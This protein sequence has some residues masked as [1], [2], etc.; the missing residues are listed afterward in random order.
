MFG[1]G[2]IEDISITGECVGP[3]KYESIQFNCSISFTNL[4]Q[5]NM[6]GVQI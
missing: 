4:D 1:S 3:V 2:K 6:M 5:N